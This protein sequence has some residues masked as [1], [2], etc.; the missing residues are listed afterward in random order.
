MVRAETLPEAWERAVL[1]TWYEGAEIKT[2]YDKPGDP[3]SRD[4]SMIIVVGQ[5]LEEPRIHRSFPGGLNH[6]E[7]YRQEVVNG[8][9]D[10]WIN[11]SPDSTRWDYTYHQ[12]FSAYDVM[13]ESINQ[14]AHVVDKLVK[15]PYSRRAQAITWQPWFDPEIIDP[16]CLQRIWF[17]IIGNKLIANIHIR[18]NDAYKAAFMNMFAFVDLQ[19]KIAEELSERLEKPIEVG[20]YTHIAD[21]F[22]IYGSYFKEFEHFLKSVED[23]TWEER[24]WSMK[25]AEPFFK[26]ARLEIAKKAAEE[27]TGKKSD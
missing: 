23:R 24:T 12:R 11:K 4:C 14:L 10:S 9:H 1:Q 20:Q 6:L 17:R 16:P 26:K 5:P 18:S 27:E 7:I 25:F 22:H 13:G 2:E 15:T 3:L 21:S 8:I 19:R